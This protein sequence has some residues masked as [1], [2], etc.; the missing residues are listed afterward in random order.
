MNRINFHRTSFV[1]LASLLAAG[2]AN[3]QTK[4]DVVNVPSVNVK[5]LPGVTVS[6]T[7]TVKVESLPPVTGNVNVANT[8]NVSIANTPS[9][10]VANTPTVTLQSGAS[11][12]VTSLL[13]SQGNPKPLATLEAVQLYGAFCQI[14]FAGQNGGGCTFAA[15]PTG[16]ELYIQE[17]DAW[18]E[19]ET[20]NRPTYLLVGET[21]AGGNWF[22]YTFL[23]N[24]DGYDY[25][26]THEETRLYA[27]SGS[28]PSCQVYLPQDSN[29]IY[30]CNIS[31]FLVDSPFGSDN[32]VTPKQS[33]PRALPIGRH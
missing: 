31:G 18:G 3:A 30:G 23:A 13:D 33:K 10:N 9:V 1:F 14:S 25:V 19:V 24:A 22:P 26:T 5:T 12:A 28:T 4:V 20:G 15:V 2:V 21:I 32:I 8:P 6:G 27:L 17:F 11:V 29:G 16:K 7:P